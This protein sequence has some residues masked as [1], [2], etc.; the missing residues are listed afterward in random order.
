MKKRNLKSLNLNKKSISRLN[1]AEQDSVKGG[2]TPLSFHLISIMFCS[3]D[4]ANSNNGC[5]GTPDETMT[6][7]NYS[8]TCQK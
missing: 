5:T 1:L 6:C 8:C 4:P 7:E 3:N 2:L